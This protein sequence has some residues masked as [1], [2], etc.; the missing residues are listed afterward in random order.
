MAS[1]VAFKAFNADW[2]CQTF[3]YEVG[4]TYKHQGPVSICDSGFHACT[5]PFDC[6]SYYPGST[7]LARVTLDKVSNEESQVDSKIVAGKI[8]IEVSL[9]L[10]EWI[11]AQV[12][13][14][15]DLC[16]LAK[17]TLASEKHACAAATGD[18]GHAAATGYSGHAA[19]TGDSGHAAATGYRGHAAATGKNAI[20]IALGIEATVKAGAG[21]AIVLSYWKQNSKTYEWALV[22]IRSVMVGENGIKPDTTYRLDDAGAFVAVQ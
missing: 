6:W 3:K 22:G 10:P 13:T 11:K 7:N 20:A 17:G 18:S 16:K 12:Q 2:S 19:A 9:S 1:V 14:V 21:G 4:Q 15:V 5:V 8:T